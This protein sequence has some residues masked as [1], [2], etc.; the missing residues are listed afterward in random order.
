MFGIVWRGLHPYSH[1][2]PLRGKNRRYEGGGHYQ[3]NIGQPALQYLF[4]SV[5]KKFTI[6]MNVRVCEIF[7]NLRVLH[8]MVAIH[9]VVGKAVVC[10]KIG[11]ITVDC[12]VKF[13]VVFCGK[14]ELL[15]IV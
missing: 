10:E 12:V 11:N 8:R 7:N 9:G 13:M 15:S 5:Y 2:I 14:I 6:R 4:R 3:Y 1:T